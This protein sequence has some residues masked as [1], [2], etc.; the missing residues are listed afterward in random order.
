MS[1]P[2]EIAGRRLAMGMWVWFND[3]HHQVVGHS[4]SEVHLHSAAGQWTAIYI[5]HLMAASE[6]RLLSESPVELPVSNVDP[7]ALLDGLA[8]GKAAILRD[9]EGHLNE[10]WKGYRSGQPDQA[11]PGEPRPSYD[12]A[13]VPRLSD[14]LAA[15]A[16]E[17]G[18]GERTLWRKLQRY[19]E[20]KRKGLIDGRGAEMHDPLA[21]A[22]K[23]VLDAIVVQHTIAERED[24]TVTNRVLNYLKIRYV[25]PA[26]LKPLALWEPGAPH[27]L[28]P[29]ETVENL[30]LPEAAL[31]LAGEGRR[32]WQTTAGVRASPQRVRASS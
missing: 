7:G 9:L 4:G 31:L 1:G 8:E 10:M 24:S 19:R 16:I 25:D 22:D 14:R 30:H 2:D 20:E 21:R 12:P 5:S 29:A 6:F 17:L 26:L 18:M 11:E 15:K 23:R 28:H 3:E 32:P 27:H 13:L